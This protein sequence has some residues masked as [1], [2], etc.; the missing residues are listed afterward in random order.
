MRLA[1]HSR[2][3]MDIARVMRYYEEVAG[4]QLADEFYAELYSRFVTVT[5]TPEAFTRHSGD[6]RR[7]NLARF[8]YHFLYRIAADHVLVLV[9]RHHRRHPNVGLSRR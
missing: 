3:A 6:L 5:K 4:N 2:V 9:V 7:V 1:L 8:P